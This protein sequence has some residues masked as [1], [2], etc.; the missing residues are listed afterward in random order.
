MLTDFSKKKDLKKTLSTL[1]N[2]ALALFTKVHSVE[3][4][5]MVQPREAGSTCFCFSAF[6]T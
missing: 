5:C 3:G 2:S 1:V 4:C 6:Q